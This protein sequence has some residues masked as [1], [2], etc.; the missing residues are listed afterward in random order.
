MPLIIPPGFAQIVFGFRQDGD[1]EDMLSTIGVELAPDDGTG[2]AAP[3]RMFTT[4]QGAVLGALSVHTYLAHVTAYVGQDGGP[5]TVEESTLDM[6]PGGAG[7]EVLPPNCAFL[8]RKRTSSAGRRGR[9]RM[10][11]PGVPE[12]LVD[13]AGN[14]TGGTQ[15]DL[16]AAVDGWLADLATPDVGGQPYAPVILHRSEG[17]GVEPAPTPVTFFE[18][19]GKIATQRRRLRP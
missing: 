19:E 5:P 6:E 14:L 10:Y 13:S 7:G 11:L 17:A 3:N 15:A 1:P 4:F 18:A 16:Q 12:A 2:A 9:G 8:V